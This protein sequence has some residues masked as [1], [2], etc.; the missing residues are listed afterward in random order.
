MKN[1]IGKQGRIL[2]GVAGEQVGTVIPLSK[3]PTN[4]RGIP[5][6]G[7]GSYYPIDHKRDIAIQLKSGRIEVHRK[8][9]VHVFDGKMG[10]FIIEDDRHTYE[11]KDTRII[12]KWRKFCVMTGIQ[13][14]KEI[15]K[16][17]LW[18]ETIWDVEEQCPL[19]PKGNY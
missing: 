17:I 16:Q 3:V 2:N 8:S 4:G 5:E 9:N 10:R 7:D 15:K 11:V 1:I 18:Q 19:P 14:L 12:G 6:V 13:L